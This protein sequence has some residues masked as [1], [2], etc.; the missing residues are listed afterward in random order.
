MCSAASSTARAAGGRL[1][2][3]VARRLEDV[4]EELHVLRV[5]LDDEDLLARH[6]YAC[7]A[8]S[9]NTNVDPLAE[10]AVDPDPA[11][12]QLDEPLRERKPEAGALALLDACLGLLELLEDPL[13]ILGR[14]AGTGV[15]DRDP[16]LAV[17]PRRAHVDGP[18]RRA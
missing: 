14:D 8:G 13:L 5:V 15:G 12:V 6:G 10:L 17:D 4:T 18:A 9:V 7:P 2:R 11:A 16:H 3:A 1:E